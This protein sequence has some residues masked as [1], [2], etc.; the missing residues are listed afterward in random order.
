MNHFT[1]LC[2]DL[3]PNHMPHLTKSVISRWYKKTE[4]N[5]PRGQDDN[6]G[7]QL[8]GFLEQSRQICVLAE[9]EHFLCLGL[10]HIISQVVDS[11]PPWTMLFQRWR[12]FCFFWC[13]FFLFLR[14]G[15]GVEK[16]S[17]VSEKTCLNEKNLSK[18]G[19]AKNSAF[20][21]ANSR[22]S[23]FQGGT[24]MLE[25]EGEEDW[26]NRKAKNR[27]R[28]RK[29]G[30]GGFFPNQKRKKTTKTGRNAAE[31]WEKH[32]D[33]ACPTWPDLHALC[34]KNRL[35]ILLA[36]IHAFLYTKIKKWEVGERFFLVYALTE[37]RTHS[38]LKS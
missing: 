31:R 37:K 18:L 14:G 23:R 25:E 13:S 33:C 15:E 36:S 27:W 35:A 10:G 4:I 7:L 26:C 24:C 17:K 3:T 32:L 30:G 6:S 1:F 19:A 8:F 28:K 34:Q 2:I 21:H 29:S 11:S 20:S 38:R 12:F 5:S 9:Q 16:W 22:E